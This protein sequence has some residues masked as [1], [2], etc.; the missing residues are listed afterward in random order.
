M[1]LAWVPALIIS[2]SWKLGTKAF[3]PWVWL[4]DSTICPLFV[5]RWVFPSFKKKRGHITSMTIE[6]FSS[7][8]AEARKI[9]YN[10]VNPIFS[11]F[12]HRINYINDLT[13]KALP[14]GVWCL[15]RSL[16][17]IGFIDYSVERS[18]VCNQVAIKLEAVLCIVY[19]VY[20]VK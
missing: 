13:C 3:V 11:L 8:E 6:K 20:F 19:C 18:T 12:R 4:Q 14:G 7:S 16:H 17:I 1:K 15:G 10:T 2:S 9:I 5:K